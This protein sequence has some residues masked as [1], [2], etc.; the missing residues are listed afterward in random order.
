MLESSHGGEAAGHAFLPIESANHDQHIVAPSFQWRRFVRRH[1]LMSYGGWA[2]V[3]GAVFYTAVAARHIFRELKLVGCSEAAPTELIEFVNGAARRMRLR[4]V[5]VRTIETL[6]SPVVLWWRRP[7]LL[8]P[9]FFGERKGSVKGSTGV[10]THELA[11]VRRGDH[12]VVWLEMVVAVVHWWN[13]VF[14]FVRRHL[15]ET[16][17]MACDA[18]A[19]QNSSQSRQE[20][21]AILMDMTTGQSFRMSPY[22][23]VGMGAISKSSL[24]R[25]IAMIFEKNVTARLSIMG[26]LVAG[27]LSALLLVGIGESHGRSAPPEGFVATP[28]VLPSTNASASEEGPSQTLGRPGG[29]SDDARGNTTPPGRRPTSRGAGW[30][31]PV[32]RNGPRGIEIEQ[33]ACGDTC[34]RGGLSAPEEYS[35]RSG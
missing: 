21:V 4:H 16:R 25:R 6:L 23:V 27:C 12:L 29:A 31:R 8:W 26:L 35:A 5:A 28:S 19:L 34:G 3:S 30:P 9:A 32:P 18:I 17:E 14:W 10:L 33:R 7:L 15:R 22:P 11:H 20:Y 24:E 13:P 2:W 1:S